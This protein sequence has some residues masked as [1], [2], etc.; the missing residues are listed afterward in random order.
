VRPEDSTRHELPAGNRREDLGARPQV[1]PD[2]AEAKD[3][4]P[5]TRLDPVIKIEEKNEE[6]KLHE[7]AAANRKVKSAEAAL[8]DAR[9]AARTDHRRAA[10]ATDWML[11]ENAHT[12]ALSD[13]RKAERAAKLAVDEEGAA[14][15]AYTIAHS[16]AE[17]LRR[18]A[19]ARV[20]EILTAREKEESK[21][22]D[23][24]GL[25]TFNGSS[26]QRPS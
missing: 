25:I 21:E 1:F 15:G 3:M 17:A 4:R 14:R 10:P 20:N 7:M 26:G 5:R 11:A 23:E 2:G 22:L 9:D 12:R 16:K 6:R 13:V 8:T 24:I 19:Q 18:V